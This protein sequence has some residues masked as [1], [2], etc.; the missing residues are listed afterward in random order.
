MMAY[1]IRVQCVTTNSHGTI[2]HIGGK[3]S[4]NSNWKETVEKAIAQIENGTHQY[5]VSRNN[6][7]TDVEVVDGS[8]GKYL[9]TKPDSSTGNNL[10]DLPDCP[11]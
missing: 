1:R 8:A 2:T 7:E 5:Y 6:K 3:R 4:D 9:R 11:A 10:S